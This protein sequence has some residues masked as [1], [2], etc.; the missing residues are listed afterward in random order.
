MSSGG[1]TFTAGATVHSWS[2][3]RRIF[4]GRP[5]RG[6]ITYANFPERLRWPTDVHC[7]SCHAR[8]TIDGL[9]HYDGCSAPNRQVRFRLKGLSRLSAELGRLL[10]R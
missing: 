6:D 3:L 5:L 2:D 10:S 8:A 7:G 4:L 1:F 9:A